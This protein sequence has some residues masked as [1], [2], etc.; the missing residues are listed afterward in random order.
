MDNPTIRSVQ[1]IP[2]GIMMVVRAAVL[3]PR[4]ERECTHD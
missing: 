1:I 3:A 2:A 4:L